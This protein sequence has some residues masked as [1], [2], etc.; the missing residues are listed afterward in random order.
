MVK[1]EDAVRFLQDKLSY[2]GLLPKEY[3]DFIVYWLP[4]L[5]ENNYNLI[6]FQE[7]SYTDIAKLNITPQ[8]DSIQR[9]FMTFKGLDKPIQIKEQVLQP[10]KREGFTVIEWGGV[11]I[12]E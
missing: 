2:L 3:N 7:E 6:V 11:E 4:L 10:F 8:P 12:T 5:Q 1:K 9:V